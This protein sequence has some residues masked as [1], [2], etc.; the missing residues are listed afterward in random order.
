[1]VQGDQESTGDEDVE[2]M[3]DKL[4][5]TQEKNDKNTP[6]KNKFYTKLIV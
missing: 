2:D 1:M 6:E 4:Q 5:M 3:G